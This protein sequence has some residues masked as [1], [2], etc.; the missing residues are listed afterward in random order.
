MVWVTLFSL[1]FPF[2]TQFL[3][4]EPSAAGR[5]QDGGAGD[6]EPGGG[7]DPHLPAAALSRRPIPARA[8]RLR[9]VQHQLPHDLRPGVPHEV[10]PQE[11]LGRH[12]Q[13]EARG[14]AQVSGVRGVVQGTAP[15]HQAHDRAPGQGGGRQ[16][17]ET[18]GGGR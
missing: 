8:E 14:E 6:E 9:Q 13:E 12:E 5:A 15:P 16:V 4:C 7:G 2:F 11:R 3:I 18:G 10:A 17:I 1:P